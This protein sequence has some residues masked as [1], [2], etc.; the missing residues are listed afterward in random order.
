MNAQTTLTLDF[1][2]PRAFQ[3]RGVQS[4]QG[5]GLSIRFKARLPLAVQANLSRELWH[6]ADNYKQY[7]ASNEFSL[8]NPILSMASGFISAL[9]TGGLI[10]L[11][12]SI[13][14]KDLFKYEHSAA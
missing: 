7:V 5:K 2:Q 4:T 8:S 10:D 9:L 12:E 14:L 6:Y 3:R 13:R 1:Q 11:A